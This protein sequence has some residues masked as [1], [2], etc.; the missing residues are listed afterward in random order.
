MAKK[1]WWI[2]SAIIA[3]LA[4]AGVVTVGVVT[5]ERYSELE[6]APAFA[7]A[8][9]PERELL[10]AQAEGEVDNTALAARLRKL[11]DTPDLGT[12]GARVTDAVS[13]EVVFEQNPLKALRPASS[14]KV[15]T[16]AAAIYT[17]EPT[18]VLSTEV[19]AGETP[20]TVV[21]RAAGDVWLTPE[22]ITELAEQVG[23]AE[24]VLIDTSLWSGPT[25]LDSWD[26]G[27]VDG[28]YVAPMEP[29][30]IHQGRIGADSGDVPRS[31]TPALD[32]AAA[33]AREV[34]ATDTGFGSAPAE[35]QLLASTDSPPLIH[36][37]REM[38]VHSDNVMA[39]AIG[40][41]VAL[42]R[43]ESPDFAGATRATLAALQEHSFDTIN[44]SLQDN[45]GLSPQNLITPALLDALLLDA[46]QGSDL[47]EV[48][49]TLPVAAGSGTLI[50]RYEDLA[51]RGWVRA[52]TG[53]LTDT[54]ALAGVVTSRSGRV[55]TFA[56]LSN[57]API[58]SQREAL[59]TFA[60]AI[61]EN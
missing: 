36:R 33:L 37:V 47:A 48:L 50:E 24:R 53:T 13:G 44:T 51:G 35:A 46:A 30:M 18:K 40:R 42:A 32:V 7:L 5:Q 41:E 55:Y 29:A 25:Y 2:S 4:V 17:L 31:H 38:M 23:T 28:G 45:S 56:L 6:H 9:A 27:N 21:I 15:L 57:D 54:S 11:A 1:V 19:V 8:E 43:G 12:F 34:G 26:E 52:K 10:P 16:S 58:L 22:N 49:R 14:T 61:R 20:G 39:E 60:S 59:D 3:G